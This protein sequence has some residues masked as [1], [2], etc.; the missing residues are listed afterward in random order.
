MRYHRYIIE[1]LFKIL[2]Q[3]NKQHNLKSSTR[4]RNSDVYE[5]SFKRSL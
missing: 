3:S 5:T 4:I 2:K 1:I